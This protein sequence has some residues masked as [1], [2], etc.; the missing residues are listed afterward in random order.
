MG[1]Y[2]QTNG[3]P[4]DAD[5][6]IEQQ[7]KQPLLRIF[8][9]V[10]GGDPAKV[11]SMLFAGGEGRRAS[12]PSTASK[13]GLGAFFKRGEKCIACNASVAGAEAFCKACDGTEKADVARS[14]KVKE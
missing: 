13:A 4:I 2:A 5:Y 7:L 10:V 6:Y 8:E 9:P 11:T 14:A 3:L 1:R 12:A